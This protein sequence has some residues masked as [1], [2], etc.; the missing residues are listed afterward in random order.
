MMDRVITGVWVSPGRT[1]IVVQLDDEDL[2]E[3]YP[4][5]AD[6]YELNMIGADWVTYIPEYTE[7]GIDHASCVDVSQA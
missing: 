2:I 5:D 6:G 3:Y 7:G 4:S 1:R